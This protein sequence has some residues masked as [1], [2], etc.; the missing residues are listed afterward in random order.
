M[1]YYSIKKEKQEQ[2]QEEVSTVDVYVEKNTGEEKNKVLVKV[3]KGLVIAGE[4]LLAATL[5]ED[6]AT[7]GVG[8]VDDIVTVPFSALL[9]KC[10]K[11]VLKLAI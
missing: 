10:G 8:A 7:G 9:K 1:V 3:G 4:V 5:L 2:E 11:L 6:V